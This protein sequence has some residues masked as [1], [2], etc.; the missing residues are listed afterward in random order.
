MVAVRVA[1]AA[2]LV[3]RPETE[4]RPRMVTVAKAAAVGELG[5]YIRFAERSGAPEGQTRWTCTSCGYGN[6]W[7][8]VWRCGWCGRTCNEP[9]AGK[10]AGKNG[11]LEGGVEGK[12]KRKGK[13]KEKGQE[14]GATGANRVVVQVPLPQELALPRRMP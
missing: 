4:A 10:G 13:G 11:E 3:V 1:V 8:M 7:P 9:V 14:P 2:V 6:N 5:V 12:G